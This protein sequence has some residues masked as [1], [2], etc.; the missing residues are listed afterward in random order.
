LDDDFESGRI[1][2]ADY[3]RQ[4]AELKAEL[5]ELMQEG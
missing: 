4:R 3:R 2:E 5:K 1:Q